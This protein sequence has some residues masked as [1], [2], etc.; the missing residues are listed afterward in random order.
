MNALPSIPER[1][2]AGGDDRYDSML[3]TDT[4]MHPTIPIDSVV[5]LGRPWF[6]W[7]GYYAI[8]PDGEF[9]GL[10]RVQRCGVGLSFRLDNWPD[11]H[12]FEIPLERVAS[13]GIRQVA[14]VAK[15]FRPEF[16]RFLRDRFRDRWE[17]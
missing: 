17:G 2:C 4:N 9:G 11:P 7:D 16:A 1:K 15:P 13:M 10:Y 6:H 12:G 14:G 8:F 3:V 5:F